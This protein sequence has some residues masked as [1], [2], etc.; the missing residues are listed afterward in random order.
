[1]KKYSGVLGYVLAITVVMPVVL[2]IISLIFFQG[3]RNS[4]KDV[5]EYINNSKTILI[6]IPDIDTENYSKETY[7]FKM[8]MKNN[9]KAYN[10]A[11]FYS[12]KY[13]KYFNIIT[14]DRIEYNEDGID[15]NIY[16]IKEIFT[17]NKKISVRVN[18]IQWDNPEYG[19]KENPLPLFSI[20]LLEIDGQKVP[21]ESFSKKHFDVS[22][23]IN[24]QFVDQYLRFFMP[25]DEFK[26]MFRNK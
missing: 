11:I 18:N 6:E 15:M 1:M 3:N 20:E 16:R 17:N 8:G 24:K 22:E 5:D 23:E 25:E 4:D 10:K 19:T 14:F 21:E 12:P 7:V 2:W 13:D 26:A 9:T